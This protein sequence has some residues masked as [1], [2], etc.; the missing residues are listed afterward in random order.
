[1][2]K[3]LVVYLF[4]SLFISTSLFAQDSTAVKVVNP[5][6][7][8]SEGYYAFSVGMNFGQYT[9]KNEDAYI[10]YIL[11]EKNIKYNI[12]LGFSYNI[13][14]NR[15]VGLSFRY[16]NDDYNILYENAIGDT[17]NTNTL[18][19]YYSIGAFYAVT[20]P[21]FKS[22]R[23]N[24]ISDPGIIFTTGSTESERTFGPITEY[25]ETNLR[26]ISIGLHV[27]IQVFLAPRLSAQASVGPV[28]VGYQW[29]DFELDGDPNGSTENFF[30]R[31]SPDVLSLEFSISRY[32]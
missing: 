12:K 13:K 15:A 21:L 27:G 25:S 18:E 9:S 14:D 3:Y 17:I 2:K 19:R 22:R 16:V 29:E 4:S 20:K 26:S 10:Y 6:E 11:D 31:M 28:G 32:F 1:M 5:S 30:I 7:G 8:N 23:V 24:M